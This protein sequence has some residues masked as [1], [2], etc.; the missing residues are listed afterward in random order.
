LDIK[1]KGREKESTDPLN[2]GM[3]GVIGS[4]DILACPGHVRA[5]VKRL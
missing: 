2:A 1:I 4:L 3:E 5:W